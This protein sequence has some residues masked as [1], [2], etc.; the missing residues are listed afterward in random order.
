VLF[1]VAELLVS[2]YSTKPL[3]PNKV[4]LTVCYYQSQRS[5]HHECSPLSGVASIC[6]EEEQSWKLCHG[7]S[8]ADFRAGSITNNF[9]TNAVVQLIERTVSC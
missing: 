8:T 2:I 5:E 1:A 4:S 7:A 6:C 9:V 3:M